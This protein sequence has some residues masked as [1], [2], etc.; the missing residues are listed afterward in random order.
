MAGFWGVSLNA[1]TQQPS[2][3]LLKMIILGCEMGG[4]TILGN[5]ETPIYDN[6]I[7]KANIPVTWI[8]WERSLKRFK[9]TIGHNGITV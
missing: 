4:T 1:S 3:F 7:G 5:P 9:Q 2:V 8:L 6:C